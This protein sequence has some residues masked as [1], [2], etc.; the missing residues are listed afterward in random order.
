MS[1]SP[2]RPPRQWIDRHFRWRGRDVTRIEGLTDGVFAIVLALLFLRSEAP[3]NFDELG[4]AMKSLVPFAATFVIIAYVWFELWR[5]ARRYALRD[6]WTI[7]LNLLQLFLLLSY[8][9][10]L[11]FLFTQLAVL[12]FGPIGDLDL[13]S[14]T[15]GG[16]QAAVA[17]MFAFYAVG[18][19]AIF[20]S[21]GLMYW[22]A[23][24]LADRLELTPVERLLTRISIEQ[25]LVQ[26]AAALASLA[27]ALAG[28]TAFGAPGWVYMFVGPVLGVHGA[29][30]DR[31]LQRVLSDDSGPQRVASS[32][33]DA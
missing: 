10:P 6:G 16:T 33:E 13:E 31:R 9:Y 12:L 8:A 27:I 1:E 30:S 24:A 19:G 26:V 25:S 18:Y 32:R 7:T 17:R 29:R 22:R 15:R 3:T 14:V 4:S 5:F 2:D 20:G 28:V 21:I 11:K 23:L